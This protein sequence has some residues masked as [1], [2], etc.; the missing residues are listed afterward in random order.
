MDYIYGK[1]NYETILKTYT[2]MP[3]STADVFIDND[4]NI[5]SANV[6][7]TPGTLTITKGANKDVIASFNGEKDTKVNLDEID[8]YR[9]I[10]TDTTTTSINTIDNT[11]AVDV[12][13]TKGTIRFEKDGLPI[14]DSEFDGS[15]DTLVVIPQTLINC[16]SEDNTIN[17]STEYV[18]NHQLNVRAQVNKVP[19]KLTIN[20]PDGSVKQFDGSSA[21]SV[22]LRKSYGKEETYNKQEIDKKI[23][24]EIEKAITDAIGGSY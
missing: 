12:K 9:G 8:P 17:L 15:S 6:K 1:L 19:N 22:T 13:R 18:A 14:D 3:T 16:E 10:E 7:R 4:K 2:A 20:L 23:S 24:E 21:T 11:I 5:I